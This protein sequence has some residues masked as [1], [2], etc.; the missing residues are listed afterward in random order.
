MSD[1]Q[2]VKEFTEQGY[3]IKCPTT[4]IAMN[5]DEVLFAIRMVLSE[6]SELA[7]TVTNS[8]EEALE[9]MAFAL[10]KIDKPKYTDI[11]TM[12]TEDIICDQADSAVDSHYYLCNIFSKKGM[13]LS[14]VFQ[15][16]HAANMRKR[17]PKTGQF[18]RRAEDNK[19][20][21]PDGWVGPDIHKVMFPK[22]SPETIFRTNGKQTK[23]EFEMID[24]VLSKV[25]NVID[26]EN[27]KS[28]NDPKYKDFIFSKTS[29][30]ECTLWKFS[31]NIMLGEFQLNQSLW[32]KEV[33]IQYLHDSCDYKIIA[34]STVP[35]ITK[36][37]NCLF[38]HLLSIPIEKAMKMVQSFMDDSDDTKFFETILNHKFKQL[39]FLDQGKIDESPDHISWYFHP[40]HIIYNCSRDGNNGLLYASNVTP[41]QFENFCIKYP[42]ESIMYNDGK[43]RFP[44]VEYLC[45]FV[46]N[47]TM[48]E[49]TSFR[50]SIGTTISPPEQTK[51]MIFDPIVSPT[52]REE[53][54]SV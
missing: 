49:V 29:N 48:E 2:L 51:V 4:Q 18:I 19:I 3:G 30:T 15:E 26:F 54:I 39:D 33:T 35:F 14:A 17:D 41:T 47:M 16:V 11:T 43:V 20:M 37:I 10:T 38:S 7:C 28:I 6:M 1:Y 8:Q 13:D 5:Y 42:L 36:C 23:K 12:S 45:M 44:S 21:K 27:T 40:Y 22:Q 24:N 46:F 34:N 50:S 9:M 32:N 52:G 53:K 31:T 25:K